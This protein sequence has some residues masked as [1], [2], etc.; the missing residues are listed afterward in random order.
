MVSKTIFKS[1]ISNLS[2]IELARI[3]E[4]VSNS[5]GTAVCTSYDVAKVFGKEHNKVCGIIKKIN[6]AYR[7]MHGADE[8]LAKKCE[9]FITGSRYQ[10]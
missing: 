2:E 1:G 7:R 4:L 3:N 10:I 6:T 9:V 8:Q 5:N